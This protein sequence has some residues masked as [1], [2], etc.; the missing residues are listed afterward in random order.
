MA[1][2]RR[3]VEA[4]ALAAVQG[5]ARNGATL[6]DVAGFNGRGG[7]SRLATAALACVWS[8]VWTI[9]MDCPIGWDSTLTI[10]GSDR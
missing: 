7:E 9:N 6:A 1:R 2:R 4:D 3:Y 8:G 5:R 10:V